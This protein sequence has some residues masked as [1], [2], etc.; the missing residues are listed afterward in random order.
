[1]AGMAG[2]K[3]EGQKEAGKTTQEQKPKESMPGM[4]M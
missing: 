4:K 3:M 1:M 2:M